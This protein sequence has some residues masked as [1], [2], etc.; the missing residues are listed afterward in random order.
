ALTKANLRDDLRLDKSYRGARFEVRTW[1][2]LERCGIHPTY[3]PLKDVGPRNP[4]FEIPAGNESFIVDTKSRPV[5]S[6]LQRLERWYRD[7]MAEGAFVRAR[8]EIHSA[9]HSLT[10]RQ[11]SLL[12]APIREAARAVAADPSRSIPVGSA[13]PGIET[14]VVTVLPSLDT[15]AL[16]PSFDRLKEAGNLTRGLLRAGAAQICDCI[17]NTGRR[18]IVLVELGHMAHTDPRAQMIEIARWMASENEGGLY[19]EVAYVFCVYRGTH[20]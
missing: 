3:E 7:L 10:D 2:A 8:I 6:D 19:R 1:A 12:T 15:C 4:D 5:V 16:V 11:R 18:G 17:K 20:S 9:I 14:D 13:I